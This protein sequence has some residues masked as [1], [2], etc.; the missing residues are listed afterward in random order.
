MARGPLQPTHPA[1]GAVSDLL[2]KAQ[3]QRLLLRLLRTPG[4]SHHLRRLLVRS[5]PAD[6]AELVPVLPP[7]E[8]NRLLELLYELKLAARVLRELDP[9][10]QGQVIA[11]LPD[12]SLAAILPRLS[13][14][15]AVDLLGG[16]AETRRDALLAMIDR[17]LA[18]RLSNLLLYG[19]STAGGL[20]TPD[21]ISF[22]EEQSVGET[23]AR[24]RQ[25]ASAGRLFYLYVIDD[26]GRLNGL[27]N[28]WQ[29]L[30]ADPE[31]RLREVMGAE[32]VKVQVDTPQEEVARVFSRYDLLMMPV[33]DAE[34]VLVGAITVDDVLDVVEE[35]ATE[36]LY[37]LANLDTQEGVG[38]A[39]RQVVRLRL[40]WLMINLLTALLAA[41][42]VKAFEATIAQMAF[43]AVF[44]PI[45]AGMGGNAGTQTLTVL[46]RGLTLGEMELRR[47]W[48]VI[49]KQA[50]AGAMNGLLSGLVL[51]VVAYAIQRNLVLS[52]ILCVA[53]V[54][55]LTVAGLFG[56][57]VPLVLRRLGLDP[58]L[59]SSIFVTTAT[60]VGGFLF[61]LGIA[62]L[63]M[64]YLQP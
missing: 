8:Q 51:A 21:V 60:D 17:P 28:L 3:R 34:G 47:P 12:G 54:A 33:V 49:G 37:H 43:L 29:L 15:D 55:N 35:E 62:T 2:P 32:V 52:A 63:L 40:P 16:L 31:R 58:A 20:M 7:A 44:L 61:F 11:G 50:L 4:D 46:V 13:L 26:H 22:R 48:G 25:L 10:T 57:S 56:A 30:T 39:A 45:V 23:L 38:T 6:L 64:R 1:A 18:Q 19:E 5:H 9:E 41:S 27:V 59:G 53:M 14:D 24:L 42:V 36:D